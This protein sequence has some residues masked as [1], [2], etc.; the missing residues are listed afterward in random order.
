[1][2]TTNPRI[3]PIQIEDTDKFGK[4]YVLS[5]TTYIEF[6]IELQNKRSLNI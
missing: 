4:I 1:M 2:H 6:A 3:Q 5:D